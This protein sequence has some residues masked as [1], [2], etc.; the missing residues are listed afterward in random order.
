MEDLTKMMI[1]LLHLQCQCG[2]AS[3]NGE[4]DCPISSC[5]GRE[6]SAS[7]SSS[8]AAI[9]TFMPFDPLSELRKDYWVRFQTFAR[10]NP[11]PPDQLPQIF[12]TN[13]NTAT[14]KLL[15]TLDAQRPG[16]IQ[17]LVGNATQARRIDSRVRQGSGKC[18]FSSIRD[19]QDRAI[20]TRFICSVNNEAVLTAVF[21]DYQLSFSKAIQISLE[22]EDAAEVVTETRIPTKD[23]FE[24]RDSKMFGS[25]GSR[26]PSSFEKNFPKGTCPHYGK[27]NHPS[28]DCRFK[29]SQCNF[30]K[31]IGHIEKADASC[32]KWILKLLAIS[33]E[34]TSA[35]ILSN[36]ISAVSSDVSAAISPEKKCRNYAEFPDVFKPELG[37]LKNFKLEIKFKP[38]A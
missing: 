12:L 11:I 24:V 19:P 18:D 16:K 3:A 27:P 23:V 35:P 2:A 10:V 34:E 26:T 37:C 31:K 7:I 30:C 8:S 33:V 4:T 28:D 25:E 22:K 36:K 6:I 29:N 21:K 38:D 32:F 14:Y 17:I 15:S 5:D 1:E 13:Q 9:P 20:R